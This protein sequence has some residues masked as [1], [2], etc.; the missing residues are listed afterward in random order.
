MEQEKEKLAANQTMA[1]TLEKRI[2]EL[3][4]MGE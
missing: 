1:A 3:K 2:A 4:G